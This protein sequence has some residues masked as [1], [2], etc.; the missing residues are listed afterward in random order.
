MSLG[1]CVRTLERELALAKT[2]VQGGATGVRAGGEGRAG[3]GPPFLGLLL[4][5]PSPGRPGPQP[6]T[7]GRRRVGSMAVLSPPRAPS[8]CGCLEVEANLGRPQA[9]GRGRDPRG[10]EREITRGGAVPFALPLAEAPRAAGGGGPLLVGRA[11]QSRSPRGPGGGSRCG[12]A[13]RSGWRA[14]RPARLRSGPPRPRGTQATESASHRPRLL[15]SPSPR[16]GASSEHL[17]RS[18]PTPPRTGP[19][20]GKPSASQ[21]PQ[22]SF[23]PGHH[24]PLQQGPVLWALGRGQEQGTPGRGDGGSLRARLRGAGQG[25]GHASRRAPWLAGV[26]ERGHRGGL[27][28]CRVFPSR[29]GARL[30]S[31]S[32]SWLCPAAWSPAAAA[33]GPQGPR[34]L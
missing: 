22:L 19:G 24:D 1:L 27:Y 33:P 21:R 2:G 32:L 34:W 13:E 28:S 10:A 4:V 31:Q 17:P 5:L 30:S 11:S 9:P 15:R 7:G 16:K 8:P 20:A 12:A 18:P 14:R 29:P 23:L 6:G 3:V 26:A 25:A